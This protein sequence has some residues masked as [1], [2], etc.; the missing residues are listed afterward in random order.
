MSVKCAHIDV[1]KSFL[2]KFAHQLSHK[3]NGQSMYTFNDGLVLNVYDTGSVV[4]QGT[5]PHGDLAEN[6]K[7]L[8]DQINAQFA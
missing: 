8:I 2:T 6:I 7:G 4:F 5:N 1:L 3:P